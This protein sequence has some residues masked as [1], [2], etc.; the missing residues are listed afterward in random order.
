MSRWH[1]FTDIKKRLVGTTI[2]KY[3]SSSVVTTQNIYGLPH[4]FSPMLLVSCCGSTVG[5]LL[6]VPL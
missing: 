2:V 3:I 4:H 6:C 1:L 5:D